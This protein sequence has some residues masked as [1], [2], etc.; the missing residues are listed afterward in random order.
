MA[1]RIP[2]L[3]MRNDFGSGCVGSHQLVSL[4]LRFSLFF[5]ACPDGCRTSISEMVWRSCAIAGRTAAMLIGVKLR[6][7]Q[8]PAS[9]Q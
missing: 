7:L 3:L 6:T 9:R 4:G 1:R 5:L 2:K 8:V